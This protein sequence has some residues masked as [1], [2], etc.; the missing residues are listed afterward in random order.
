[1]KNYNLILVYD[2]D[3][4]NIL[5][6]KRK[7]EPYKGKYNFVGGKIEPNEKDIDSAYRELKEETGI[8]KEKI[9]LKPLMNF[10]YSTQDMSLKVFA[11]KLNEN[12]KLV[13]ELNE[14]KWINKNSNFYDLNEFAGEG[15]IWHIIHHANNYLDI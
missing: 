13:E 2:K 4:E 7:K 9:K 5:M 10:E 3:K 11:G 8:D 15:N 12:V 14:L 6:C 1:M